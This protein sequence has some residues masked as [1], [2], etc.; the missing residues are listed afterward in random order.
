MPDLFFYGT[1][2]DALVRERVIRRAGAPQDLR[3][4]ILPGFAVRRVR[5]TAYPMLVAQQGASAVGLVMSGL[6][7]DEVARLDRFEGVNYKRVP[8]EVMIGDAPSSVEF[9]LPS[10]PLPEDSEPWVFEQWQRHDRDRFFNRDF[11]LDGV[12]PPA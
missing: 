12:T 5:G 3:D 2:R 4:A 11:N 6:T 7:P 10:N 8:G 1:L 9:Y